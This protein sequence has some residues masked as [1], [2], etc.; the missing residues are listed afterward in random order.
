MELD[1]FKGICGID[2]AGRGALAGPLVA[3]AV[4]LTCSLQK[5]E[6]ISRVS[7]KDG[8][9][10][11]PHQRTVIYR[12]LKKTKAFIS[13]EVISSR[14]INNHG[15][16]HANREAIR[17]LI[18][19]VEADSYIVDGN[20][21]IGRIKDKTQKVRSVVRADATI[22]PVI[23]AGIVAKVTRD[24]LMNDL[25]R[26]FPH[27]QWRQNKGY[28]TEKHLQMLAKYGNSHYHRS[29]F[30]TTALQ[31]RAQTIHSVLYPRAG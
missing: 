14:R 1:N 5:I 10:L 6:N 30:V 23:L 4:I 12:A 11:K 3:A 13:V 31:H 26:E 29:K 24:Q 17:S 22:G 7:V 16:G 19:R 21:H 28:G 18:R 2:E 15:I 9:F 27:Y 20:L 25:H 8:K